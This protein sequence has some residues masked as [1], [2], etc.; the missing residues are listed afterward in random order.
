MIVQNEEYCIS[1]CLNSVKD[2]IDE[3]IIVDTGCED[4][5]ID[6]CRTF[7]AKMYKFSWNGSFV[8][9]RNF[10]IERANGDWI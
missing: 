10:G 1:R 9:A 7:G 3:M 4:H 6:I 2:N 8:D 5:T